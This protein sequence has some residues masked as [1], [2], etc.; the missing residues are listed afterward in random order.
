MYA[1]SLLPFAII[2][3]AVL[4]FLRNPLGSRSSHE[5]QEQQFLTRAT[6]QKHSDTD[7]WFEKLLATL[8]ATMILWHFINQ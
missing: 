7:N 1:Q 8:A 3:I 5:L 2:T 6:L 4:A